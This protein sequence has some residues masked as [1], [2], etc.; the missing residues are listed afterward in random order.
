[1]LYATGNTEPI[2]SRRLYPG[3]NKYYPKI[4][5]KGQGVRIDFHDTKQVD[6][7]SCLP[8][9][10]L[11][12]QVYQ[13]KETNKFDF[14]RLGSDSP[15][16]AEYT[17]DTDKKGRG[18]LIAKHDCDQ[19][20]FRSCMPHCALS[21]HLYH[22]KKLAKYDLNGLGCDSPGPKYDTYK[23]VVHLVASV[24]SRP[25]GITI[26]LAAEKAG[27][28]CDGT[29]YPGPAQYKIV[30]KTKRRT[31]WWVVRVLRAEL[32]PL[33]ISHSERLANPG[34]YVRPVTHHGQAK[35]FRGR[36][37]PGPVYNPPQDSLV[38]GAKVLGKGY[39][40]GHATRLPNVERVKTWWVREKRERE[41]QEKADAK[42]DIEQAEHEAKMKAWK[43]KKRQEKIRALKIERGEDV[44]DD[45]DDEEL[46]PPRPGQE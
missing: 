2:D 17:P 6:F 28:G 44:D 21:Q 15:G 39:S 7:K 11:S 5:E 43:K 29:N 25:K 9:S 33:T 41:L 31:I 18:S 3:P 13:G 32:R 35:E 30:E 23:N 40:W 4:D 14:K 19:I 38:H 46:F 24:S 26:Q 12:Q 36:H 8:Y 45:D 16:P 10:A 34:V 42:H 1:M 22:G 27:K 37:S 20:D